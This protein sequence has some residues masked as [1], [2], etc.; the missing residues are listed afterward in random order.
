MS[1]NLG[2]SRESSKRE[3]TVIKFLKFLIPG[4]IQS[5]GKFMGFF[6]TTRMLVLMFWGYIWDFFWLL[7]HRGIRAAKNFAL[8]KFIVP[9]GEGAGGI[10]FFFFGW[11]I[12]K[13]PGLAIYPRYIEIEV[14]TVCNK[15][16]IMCEY[17]YWPPGT[18]EKR[19]LS[20]DEFKKIVDQFPKLT[21]TNLTGEGSSFL[22]KEYLE[23]V[24]TLKQ[25]DIPVFLVDHFDDMK[26]DVAKE[27]V[28]IP[29]EGIYLSVDGATKE[30]YEK[31]KVGCNFD[32]VTE[33][34]KKF[35]ELKKALN[36]PFPELNYRY[37]VNKLNV[38]EMP[39]FLDLIHSLGG[40]KTHG[41][42]SRIDFCG[43]LPFPE[44][45]DLVTSVPSEIIQEVIA[46]K[47]D[48]NLFVTFSHMELEKNAPIESCLAWQEPY[49]MMGGYALPCCQVLMSN[50]RPWLREHSFGNIY[51]NSFAEIWYSDR[52]K[53]FRDTVNAP[54]APVPMFCK[55]CR[56]YNTQHREENY[57][58]DYD[59]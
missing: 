17:V 6:E 18:Q 59:L 24:N 19:H 10:F 40:R 57:G 53:R 15:R 35:L 55:D 22:N 50:K 38:N 58:I 5:S 23:M 47:R 28:S 7:R 32:R 37:V 54:K 51:N 2:R 36:S 29:V 31:I 48:Y 1:N 14:T 52:Y 8:V 16:C 42:S 30:T 12:R 4:A 43:L 44:I 27:L 20:L 34:I 21:W 45:E 25:K 56:A 9:C 39:I 11:L 26:E 46:K 33:N 49:F 41:Y 3:N 13:F